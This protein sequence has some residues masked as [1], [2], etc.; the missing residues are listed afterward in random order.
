MAA[1]KFERSDGISFRSLSIQTG[2]LVIYLSGRKRCTA[3]RIVDDFSLRRLKPK[4]LT[5]V[6]QWWTHIHAS[7]SINSTECDA[8]ICTL[9]RFSTEADIPAYDTLE[10]RE[11]RPTDQDSTLRQ[12]SRK[13]RKNTAAYGKKIIPPTFLYSFFLS[14]PKSFSMLSFRF[15]HRFHLLLSC[16]YTSGYSKYGGELDS[17]DDWHCVCVCGKYMYNVNVYV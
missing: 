10:L 3:C 15:F 9:E 14:H 1:N 8:F 16:L 17:N 12:G 7:S 13:K 4:C 5:I 2:M 11:D 6:H